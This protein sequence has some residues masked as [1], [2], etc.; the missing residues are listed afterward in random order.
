MK[1][2]E[3][4]VFE[5][6]IRSQQF[7]DEN[8]V[9]LTGVV[10]LA[11][12]RKRLD[13]V[14]TS[15]T[16]HAFDQD[17]GSRGAKGETAKQRQL[18][19]Q[20]RQ[21]QMEPVAVIAR[22]NLRTTPEFVALQ[23]PKPSVF[24]QAFLASARGMADAAAIHH[25]TL[26]THGLPSTFLDTFKAGVT[27]FEASLKDRETSRN[28]RIGATKG[29]DVQV[30]EGRTVLSV[31]DG[32]M[33]QALADNQPLLRVWQAARLIRRKPGGASA[34][35]VPPVTPTPAVPPTAAPAPTPAAGQTP[36]PTPLP[37]GE[38]SPAP[39]AA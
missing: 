2:Q 13:D 25:D 1:F 32:L 6:L 18:R 21:Q 12:A 35:A 37:A 23:M 30:K 20:L 7:F 36:T 31:L 24:G 3:N 5:A 28:R 22:R 27:K 15:F 9:A 16:S 10:D 38:S 11:T 8:G 14:A 26:V 29:L 39:A 33:Q 34:A 4:A 17:A 19:V